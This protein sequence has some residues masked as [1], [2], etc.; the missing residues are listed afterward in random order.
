MTTIKY[1]S[2]DCI[3][4]DE[5]TYAISIND[6]NVIEG[7]YYFDLNKFKEAGY[8]CVEDKGEI[9]IKILEK[10]HQERHSINNHFTHDND[11][12]YGGAFNENNKLHGNGRTLDIETRYFK[13]H[14]GNYNNGIFQGYGKMEYNNSDKYEGNFDKGFR[15]GF[16]KMTYANGDIYEGD[17]KCNQKHGTG[18]LKDNMGNIIHDGKWVYD[19]KI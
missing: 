7:L 17:W 15:S 11:F 12:V 10:I 2:D 18:K 5:H 6:G 4:G 3:F 1:K 13:N 14:E 8:K 19:Y 16:G 9:C